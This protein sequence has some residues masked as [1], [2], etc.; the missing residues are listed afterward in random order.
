MKFFVL[1]SLVTTLS[2]MN[3]YAHSHSHSSNA[4]ESYSEPVLAV[5]T[6]GMFGKHAD[7]HKKALDH[8]KKSCKERGG[9]VKHGPSV[10]FQG[11]DDYWCSLDKRPVHGHG[12]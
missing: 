11:A 12:R 9:E 10:G 6:K 1:I 4:Q 7:H 8:L 2:V 5:P 3:V